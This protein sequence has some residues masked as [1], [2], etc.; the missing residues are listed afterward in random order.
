MIAHQYAI[1][2]CFL[3]IPL[4]GKSQQHRFLLKIGQNHPNIYAEEKGLEIFLDHENKKRTYS[5][6]LGYAFSK[7]N[8]ISI[9]AEA[10]FEERGWQVGR[11]FTVDEYG[12][13]GFDNIDYYYPFITIPILAEVHIGKTFQPFINGGFNLSKRIG[14]K[15][16]TSSGNIP[17]VFIFPEDKKPSV[18]YAGIFGGG[19]RLF[20]TKSMFAEI[21]YRQYVSFNPIGVGFSVDSVIKHKGFLFFGNVGYRF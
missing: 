20:F 18:D 16:I 4:S 15:A 21:E 1:L 6:G 17:Q 9:K 2:L 11:V 8:F 7:Y 5:Y 14:G 3:I 19:I 12:N 13:T 10:F